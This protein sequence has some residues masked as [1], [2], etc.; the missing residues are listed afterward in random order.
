MGSVEKKFLGVAGATAATVRV[1]GQM[2][3][4]AIITFALALFMGNNPLTPEHGPALL[5][6]IRISWLVASCLCVVAVFLSLARGNVRTQNKV[7]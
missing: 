5:Q 2:F 4:M 3:S 7:S 6:S 1:I